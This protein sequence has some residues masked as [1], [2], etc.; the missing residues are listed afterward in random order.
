MQYLGQCSTPCGVSS[1]LAGNKSSVPNSAK[2]CRMEDRGKKDCHMSFVITV[3]LLFRTIFDLFRS[4][5]LAVRLGGYFHNP[6][7]TL[8]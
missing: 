8:V 7:V 3:S 1:V 5:K 6:T 2:P 4:L